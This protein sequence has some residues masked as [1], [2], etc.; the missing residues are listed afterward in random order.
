MIIRFDREGNANENIIPEIT[1]TFC[2]LGFGHHA[3]YYTPKDKG[4]LSKIAVVIMHCDA[5][6]MSMNIG[7]ELA[8]RGF[9]TLAMEAWQSGTIDGKIE[10]LGNAVKYLKSRDDVEKIILMGHSG[11]ATLMTAYQAIA[12]NGVGIF[13]TD[14]MIYKCQV[15]GDL[16]PADGMMLLDAN[17][18]NGVMELLSLD[19]A[20]IEEGNGMKLDPEYDAFSAENGYVKDATRYSA[21]F[22]RKY[23]R[24]QAERNN[25][26]IDHAVERLEKISRGEGCYNDDEPLMLAGGSQI[27][28][29]NRLINQDISLLSHTKEPHTLI[30]GD[31]TVTC[32]IVHSLRVP[33]FDRSFTSS[34]GAGAGQNTI[35]GFLSSQAIRASED[36][37]IREDEI[38]GVDFDSSYAS[39]IGNIR[40]I[41]VPSLFIGMTGGYEYLASE[42]IYDN[43]Q[44]EDREVAF[45]RGASHNFFPERSAEAVHGSFGDT[46]NAVYDKCADWMKRFI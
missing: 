25:R 28:P 34:F 40:Y 5:N 44:M 36:F 3:M 20:V 27:K 26:I 42:M 24:A 30:S 39:P 8:R 6:Y 19:P 21:E 23:N 46:E 17:Y 13:Q 4:A 2:V 35:K 12:E 31:G 38:V 18:G 15:K 9:Q 43:A 33:E 14:K 16:I 32:E 45:V 22:I 1:E 11:G 41:K 29:N 10:H 7:P 37:E